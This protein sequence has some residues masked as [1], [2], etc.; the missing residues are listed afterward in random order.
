RQADATG[1]RLEAVVA[2]PVIEDVAGQVDVRGQRQV[3]DRHVARRA[4]ARAGG[5]LRDDV[6]QAGAGVRGHRVRDRQRR[7]VEAILRGT[8]TD[9]ARLRR[10][11]RRKSERVSAAAR[12]VLARAVVRNRRRQRHAVLAAAEVETAAIE[13][14]A[15]DAG[16]A[17]AA[18]R[19]ARRDRARLTGFGSTD[20]RRR[21]AVGVG[22]ARVP[23]VHAVEAYRRRDA[24]GRGANRGGRREPEDRRIGRTART[25][26]LR[27]A[28]AVVVAHL[29]TAA[30][31]AAGRIALLGAAHEPVTAIR[32]GRRR[33]GARSRGG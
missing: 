11:P 17:D 9:A 4:G 8:V 25:R 2:A 13:V 3:D 5:V 6:Q 33:D 19:A 27:H 30:A 29:S 12:V 31:A 21:A 7:P 22:R 16:G 24:A 32:Q 20:A 14:T 10:R 28:L 26:G 1:E 15:A 23:V 18:T